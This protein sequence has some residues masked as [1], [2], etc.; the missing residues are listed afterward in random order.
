MGGC[1][2][3][4][5][6]SDMAATAAGVD[7]I[8]YLGCINMPMIQSPIARDFDKVGAKA[9]MRHREEPLMNPHFSG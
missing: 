6:S 3:G 1:A 2:G 7:T 8:G 4:L 9:A 5:V